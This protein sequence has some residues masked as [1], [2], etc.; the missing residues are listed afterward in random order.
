ML[1]IAVSDDRVRVEVSD[2]G[3]GFELTPREPGQETASGWGL[4]L[5]ERLSDEWGIAGGTGTCVWFEMARAPSS[6]PPL[7]AV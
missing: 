3:D 4:H 7:R 5:V 2:A 6:R 1:E